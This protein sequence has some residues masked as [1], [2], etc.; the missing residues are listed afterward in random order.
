VVVVCVEI[1]SQ[2]WKAPQVYLDS[3]CPIKDLNLVPPFYFTSCL[4]EIF[5]YYSLDTLLWSYL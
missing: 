5:S 1:L 4:A 2:G 3:L